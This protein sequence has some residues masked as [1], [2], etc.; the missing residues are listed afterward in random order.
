MPIAVAFRECELAGD[1]RRGIIFLRLLAL[2]AVGSDEPQPTP[3]DVQSLD[4]GGPTT[5]LWVLDG[6]SFLGV[7]SECC[8]SIQI[9]PISPYF[10]A[11]VE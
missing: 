10:D 3:L 2:D 9:D 8:I 5:N 11:A 1:F 7:L 4:V 6:F